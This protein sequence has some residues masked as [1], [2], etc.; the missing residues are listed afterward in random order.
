MTT[1]STLTF[2]FLLRRVAHSLHGFV[3]ALYALSIIAGAFL[4][5]RIWPLFLAL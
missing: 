3:L 2:A 5:A 1:R 4:I